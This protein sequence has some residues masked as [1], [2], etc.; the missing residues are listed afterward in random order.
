MVRY[1]LPELSFFQAVPQTEA[2]ETQGKSAVPAS[3]G[4]IG[5]SAPRTLI[6]TPSLPGRPAAELNIENGY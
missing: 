5:K 3:P 1:V 2:W 6:I 4:N